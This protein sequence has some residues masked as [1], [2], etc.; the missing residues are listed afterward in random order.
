MTNSPS[1]SRNDSRPADT[2]RRLIEAAIEV[3]IRDGFH[4]LS[5]VKVCAQAGLTRG[6]IH[7][8]F[9][10]PNA[11]ITGVVAEIYARIQSNVTSDL[12]TEPSKQSFR[13]DAVDVLWAHLSGDEFRVL[14]EIRAAAAT[15]PLLAISI[16]EPND[17]I[18]HEMIAEAIQL[19]NVDEA[20]LRIILAALTG[21]A[22]Q[23]FTLSEQKRYA[24]QYAAEFIKLLKNTFAHD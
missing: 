21:M 12:K 3:L 6:A 9:N 8:H 22:L 10:T 13:G 16:A 2:K 24:D 18:A 5:F 19:Y 7:H 17:K 20:S 4:G 15:D 23:Y 11:L 14:L 1:P